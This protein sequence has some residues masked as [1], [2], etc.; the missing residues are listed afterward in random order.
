MLLLFF[1][2]LCAFV[3]ENRSRN[4]KI[5]ILNGNPNAQCK[6]FQKTEV[7]GDDVCFFLSISYVNSS[8]ASQSWMQ[9]QQNINKYRRKL[10]W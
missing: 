5:D 4:M 3:L 10:C 1:F 9:N 7:S 8:R 2:A 6:L